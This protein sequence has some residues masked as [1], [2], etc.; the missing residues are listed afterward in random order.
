MSNIIQFP[1][2]PNY[3]GKI[4]A[5]NPERAQKFQCGGFWLGP[6]MPASLVPP[7]AQMDMLHQAVLDGRLIEVGLE[8]IKTMNAALDPVKEL[9]TDRPESFF[10][11]R[12]IDGV[13]CYCLITPKDKEQEATLRQQIADTGKIDFSVFP[14][15]EQK[16]QMPTHLS[17]ITITDL[18]PNA[19]ESSSSECDPS[20]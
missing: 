13:K 16:I 4:L 8:A 17:A 20:S 1:S 15:L 3:A 18:E 7:N 9:E 5:L 12:I 11:F 2:T 6:R 19:N 10:I 14:E